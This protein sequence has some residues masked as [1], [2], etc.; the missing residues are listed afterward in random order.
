MQSLEAAL[1]GP[2]A[3]ARTWE[4]LGVAFRGQSRSSAARRAF[5]NALAAEPGRLTSLLPAAQ[6]AG[7][8]GDLDGALLLFRQ[9]VGA[10]PDFAPA[11][12]GAA[13]ILVV[14]AGVS[15]DDGLPGWSG[16]EEFTV[17]PGWGPLRG[18]FYGNPLC[19]N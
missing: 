18:P 19:V 17:K 2:T 16:W 1:R 8:V 5:L 11:L 14:L 6:L 9:A 13:G 15:L 3:D 7:S 12:L 10:A 4:A